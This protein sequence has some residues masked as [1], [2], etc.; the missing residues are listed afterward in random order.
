VNAPLVTAAFFVPL[1]VLAGIGNLRPRTLAIWTV[2]AL[3][4]CAGLAAYDIFRDPQPVS[5][6]VIPE[7]V[8]WFAIAAGLFITHALVVAGDTGRRYLAGYQTYFDGSWK[9]GLQLALAGA[10]V[11]AFW[12]VL[13]LG[14]ALF[15]LID[16]TVPARLIAHNW[17]WIPATTLAFACALHVTDARAGIMQSARVLALTP[18]AWLLPVMTLLALAFLLALPFT[19]LEPLWATRHAT[20]ILL[21]AALALVLL[22][23][24]VY[25]DGRHD[26]AR[27]LRFAAHAAALILVPLVALAGYALALRVAQYGWTPF[28]VNAAACVLVAACYAIGYALTALVWRTRLAGIAPTNIATA[29]VV[30]AVMLA[31]LTPAADP[32]RIA[33]ADQMARLRDGRITPEKFD[34]DFLRFKSGRYGLAALNE[35]AAQQPASFTTR[36]AKALLALKVRADTYPRVT[37]TPESRAANITVLQPSGQSLPDR[38][39]A[40]DWAHDA[41]SWR[42]PSCLTANSKC[43]AFMVDLDDDGAPEILLFGVATSE[44]AAFKAAA[45]GSWIYLGGIASAE[46]PGVNAQVRAPLQ[47]VAPRFKEIEVGQNRLRVSTLCA[48]AGATGA[49]TRPS[50]KAQ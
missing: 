48:D 4:L 11:G 31:L 50:I 6:R 42:L 5:A 18:L 47:V 41:L 20:V 39:L 1:I 23:N 37:A 10:F 22:T 28:R 43:N 26:A 34:F 2:I 35:L 25:Q 27:P 17:F 19:G 49:T 13:Y 36:R 33:V 16:I 38:F 45:D 46:C 40:K 15:E 12:L 7:P 8:V 14:V 44:A 3:A 32:A 21:I 24:V 29:L 30:L 9:L